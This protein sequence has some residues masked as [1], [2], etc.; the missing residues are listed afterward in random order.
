MFLS[1]S[2]TQLSDIYTVVNMVALCMLA[3][4]DRAYSAKKKLS[5]LRAFYCN[6]NYP[7]PLF[8]CALVLEAELVG[9]HINKPT[10]C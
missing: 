8:P 6:W 1:S 2:R 10:R 3:K 4:D 9:L 7:V 5:G